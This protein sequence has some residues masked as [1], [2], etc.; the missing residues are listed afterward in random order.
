MTPPKVNSVNIQPLDN[1]Y[2]ENLLHL[3]IQEA[4]KQFSGSD[5]VL[6][7]Q[8]GDLKRIWP[9]AK[10]KRPASMRKPPGFN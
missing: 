4:A 7:T 9:A 6:D 5:L 10:P 2:L 1:L 3:D 8:T